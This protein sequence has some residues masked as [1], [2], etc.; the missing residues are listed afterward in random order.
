[1]SNSLA[2]GDRDPMPENQATPEPG[3]NTED[4]PTPENADA[5]GERETGEAEKPAGD[6][7]EAPKPKRRGASQRIGELVNERKLLE[8]EN[9]RLYALLQRGEAPKQA[10]EPKEPQHDQFDDYEKYLEAKAAY[11]AERRFQELTQRQQA[12]AMKERAARAAREIND[13]WESSHSAA[14][15]S[16]EDYEDIFDEVGTSINEDQASAIKQAD[17]PAD[18]VYYLG[19]NPKSLEK[20]RGL[21]GVALLREVGR[22][23]ERVQRQKGQTSSAPKPVTPARGAPPSSNEPSDKDDI[24]TWI[25]KRNRQLG[26]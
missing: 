21:E 10:E 15:D 20:L 2:D 3:A 14:L 7:P 26:R 5:S 6:E 18:L 9:A 12:D 8:A 19:K 13:R 23:E 4:S 1:M 24:K 22:L 11:V 25:A 16:Y 17:N